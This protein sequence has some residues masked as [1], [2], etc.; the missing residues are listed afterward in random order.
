MFLE[1]RRIFVKIG[2][3]DFKTQFD[4]AEYGGAPF[5]GVKG[6]LIKAHG[7][8]DGKAIKNAV[9]QGIKFIENNVTNDIIKEIS[10]L[11]DNTVE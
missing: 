4:Y 10:I 11:R 7:S 8:S 9:R 3:K 2:L 5:L 6:V 1:N